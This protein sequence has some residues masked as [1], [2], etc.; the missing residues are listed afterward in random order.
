MSVK[1]SPYSAVVTLASVAVLLQAPLAPFELGVLHEVFAIDR[2]TDGVPEFSFAI[3]TERPNLPISSGPLAITTTQGLEACVDA[4]LIAVPGGPMPTGAS[5]A[6]LSHLRDA[7]ERG[8]IVLGMC[9]GAFTLAEAGVL[10]G[11][12]A[13]IHWRYAEVF[14]QAFPDIEVDRDSIFRVEGEVVTSAGTGAGI[15]ACLQLVRREHGPQIANRIA[16]RM[17][18]PL[19]REGGQRQYIDAPLPSSDSAATLQPLLGWIDEHLG[20]PHSL[21]SLAARAHMS[22]RTLNRRFRTEVGASPM[23]WLT[24]RRV[25]W[26]QELLEG[27]DMSVETVAVMAGFG[28]DSAFRHHFRQRVGITPTAY[29]AKFR[30]TPLGSYG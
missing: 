23:A 25:C 26:A 6:V 10:A 8:A 22:S 21:G 28:N 9:S 16:K 4:D 7:A 5:P 15:D 30:T 2:T 11:R 12:T 20:H 1:I 29:R 17:V 24:H 14:Q 3:C 19:H 13:A 27:T 18:V